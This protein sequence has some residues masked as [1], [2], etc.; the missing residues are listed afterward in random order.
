MR[1]LPWTLPSSV[2]A[3]LSCPLSGCFD[4]IQNSIHIYTI[5]LV[6]PLVLHGLPEGGVASN[7]L[8]LTDSL[9]LLMAK[10]ILGTNISFSFSG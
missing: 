6:T 10:S 7:F 3:R 8:G 1:T 5:P 2:I 4:V 9:L